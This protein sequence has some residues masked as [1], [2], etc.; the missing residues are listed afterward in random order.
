MPDAR[1]FDDKRA[2]DRAAEA[3]RWALVAAL[4]RAYPLPSAVS[5]A[6]ETPDA[7]LPDRAPA[8]LLREGLHDRRGAELGGLAHLLNARRTGRPAARRGA[9]SWRRADRTPAGVGRRSR[10]AR[11]TRRHAVVRIAHPRP[12]PRCR[13]CRR[14]C[15]AACRRPGAAASRAS[16]PRV[17]RANRP[18]AAWNT[19]RST[20]SNA[21]PIR[22]LLRPP[23]IR[24]W[25]SPCAWAGRDWSTACSPSASAWMRATATA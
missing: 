19:S 20:C 7:P 6:A 13:R 24:R 14:C 5:D 9:R 17:R 1:D 21:A 12:R 10:R 25:R 22:S 15:A 23:A 18:R 4:D 2:I 16:L 11:C 8:A 3:G